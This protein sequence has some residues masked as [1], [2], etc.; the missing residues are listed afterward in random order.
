MPR[1]Q[2]IEG[3]IAVPFVSHRIPAVAKL[4]RYDHFVIDD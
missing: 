1:E 2:H 4:K 3:A